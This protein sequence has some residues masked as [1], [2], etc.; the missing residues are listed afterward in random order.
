MWLTYLQHVSQL[1]EHCPLLICS[2]VPSQA[3]LLLLGYI[4]HHLSMPQCILKHVEGRIP[5]HSNIAWQIGNHK[6]QLFKYSPP[7]CEQ[8]VRRIDNL[9]GKLPNLSCQ[10]CSDMVHLT[11]TT[12]LPSQVLTVWTEQITFCS[13]FLSSALISSISSTHPSRLLSVKSSLTFSTPSSLFPLSPNLWSS[14]KSCT[15]FSVSSSASS[16]LPL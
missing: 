14:C 3:K 6:L 1:C 15:S 4:I 5:P 9:V 7:L 11:L 16:A 13:S 12:D 10:A 8:L 2:L